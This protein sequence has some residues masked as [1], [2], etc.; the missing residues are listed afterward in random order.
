MLF[1]II[2][3]WIP[4]DA[5]IIESTS[6]LPTEPTSEPTSEPTYDC[7]F[8]NASAF[9]ESEPNDGILYNEFEVN[10]GFTIT[11]SITCGSNN[12][13]DYTADYD[14]YF[15]NTECQGNVTV[16]LNWS[17]SSDLDVYILDESKE[18]IESS[19]EAGF[20]GPESLI[21]PSSEPF[22]IL[23][24]CYEGEETDYELTVTWEE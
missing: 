16:Y 4:N 2:G 6:S 9:S 23:S 21:F 5:N 22:Y 11:G 3:C 7:F 10:T 19:S 17:E 12:N 20:T 18:V 15:I 24:L 1:Y 13:G 14:Y 8:P